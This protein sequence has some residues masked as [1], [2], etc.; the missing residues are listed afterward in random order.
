[1]MVKWVVYECL[2]VD[3][4]PY[5]SIRNDHHVFWNINIDEDFHGRKKKKEWTIKLRR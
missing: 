3:N 5:G 2:V 1:M 4:I